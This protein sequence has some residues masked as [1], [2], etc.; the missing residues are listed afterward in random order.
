V[1]VG[2]GVGV[3]ANPLP[4][5]IAVG[6]AEQTKQK[7]WSSELIVKSINELSIQTCFLIDEA[8]WKHS[9]IA[10]V[11]LPS[12]VPISPRELHLAFFRTIAL[13]ATGHE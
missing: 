1:G 9:T 4:P 11:R 3:G 12:V 10:P 5:A 7:S 8:P 2:V 13:V 6:C